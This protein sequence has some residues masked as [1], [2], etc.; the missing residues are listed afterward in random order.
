MFVLCQRS[1]WAETYLKCCQWVPN[2]VDERN[3]EYRQH[4]ETGC[5]FLLARHLPTHSSLR[6]HHSIDL[7]NSA[8]LNQ[9]YAACSL[10][11]WIVHQQSN[12]KLRI[13]YVLRA[14]SF[15]TD[16]CTYLTRIA[17]CSFL[18]KSLV[19]CTKTAKYLLSLTSATINCS[20]LLP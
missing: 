1:R 9:D 18:D 11:M 20:I 14:L 6:P 13:G 15:I 12:L 3:N 7:R 10:W 16:P 17:S 4:L 8:N 2:S 5:E 19:S